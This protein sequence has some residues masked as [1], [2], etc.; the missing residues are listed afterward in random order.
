M[1]KFSHSAIFSDGETALHLA[2]VANNYEV[3]KLLLSSN[4]SVDIICKN[5]TA[6]QIATA[7]SY[8]DI[9]ELLSTFKQEHGIPATPPYERNKK[10]Y[11]SRISRTLNHSSLD[12]LQDAT[13]SRARA[14]QSFSAKSGIYSAPDLFQLAKKQTIED[15]VFHYHDFVSATNESFVARCNHCDQ[16]IFNISETSA[17]ICSVCKYIVHKGDCKKDALFTN[18][19]WTFVKSIPVG[20]E[21]SNET[22][23]A[24]PFPL[25]NK[26]PC[27]SIFYWSIFYIFLNTHFLTNQK[28]DVT[29]AEIKTL[30]EEFSLI[31]VTGTGFLDKEEFS[32]VVGPLFDFKEFIDFLFRMFDK[33]NAKKIDFVSY[34]QIMAILY[35]GSMEEKLRRQ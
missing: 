6:L 15:S 33:K 7:K 21:L 12:H 13:T 2:C 31:N 14:T 23:A 18:K 10:L 27:V 35:K 4:A 11:G 30:Y 26:I 32:M 28:T 8:F 17:F 9:V 24:G 20:E 5:G 25:D 16:R 1:P 22:P 3:V 34:A 19:C 29:V